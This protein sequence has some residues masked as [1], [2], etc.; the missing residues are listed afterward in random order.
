MPRRNPDQAIAAPKNPCCV[1]GCTEVSCSLRMQL[2]FMKASNA[3]VEISPKTGTPSRQ[4]AEQP[5]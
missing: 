2:E 4:H 1:M 5:R 3:Y